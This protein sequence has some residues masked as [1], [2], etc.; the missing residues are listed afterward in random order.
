MNI[1]IPEIDKKYEVL[2]K[3]GEG[4]M[5]AVYRARHRLLDELRVIKTIRPMLREDTEVQ[6][7]FLN[8]AQV[9][10]KLRHRHI[11]SIH[12][13]AMGDDGT[14]CIVM[15]HIEGRNLRDHQ[16]AGPGLNVPQVV[17]VARQAL[18]ALA[19]MHE[20]R[21]VHRDIS[22]DNLML[23]WDDEGLP[24]VTLID[25]GLAKSLESPTAHTRTGTVVGKARYISPE[26]LSA[27]SDGVTVD[28]RCDLYA[29]G[30]V[31]YELLTGEYPIAGDDELALI[32]GHLHRPPRSFDQTDPEHRV[33]SALRGVV[34]QALEKA[35]ADRFENADAMSK[36][37]EVGSAEMF[38]RD[39]MPTARMS[40][41][42]GAVAVPSEDRTVLMDATPRRFRL[43]RRVGKALAVAAG[44]VALVV[45]GWGLIAGGVAGDRFRALFA[46]AEVD[47]LADVFF[48]SYHALIIG[49]DA[50]QRLPH[51]STAVNDARAIGDLLQRRYGFSVRLLENATRQEIM[52]ALWDTRQSLGARDNLLVYYA[53]HGQLL[54]RSEWWQPVDAEPDNTS[55]W[56]STRYDVS[57]QVADMA[58][59][60]ALVVADSCY[61]GAIG[62]VASPPDAGSDAVAFVRERVQRSSRMVMT[63]GG[64]APVLDAGD[65]RHSVFAKAFLEVLEG[66]Q[67]V[68]AASRIFAD[69]RPRVV[70]GA[71][72]FGFEQEPVLVV[73]PRTGDEGGEL[74][75][76]PAAA[77]T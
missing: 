64:L 70:T 17:H 47:P 15:E 28:A 24:F 11:A 18:D 69:L 32:A 42:S 44:L 3:L 51:L 66:N 59:R 62:E 43:P 53:G 31:L 56:I 58:V 9:A 23:D 21:L 46:S 55:N 65:A 34:M 68:A 20:R 60:H 41:A 7:R 38:A 75:F 35:P 67:E 16:R 76:V 74:F 52:D 33:P 71:R 54:N 10:A 14:A 13:F 19:Y 27:G 63:S 39:G 49:N 57:A 48:G 2:S 4:G 5:G 61:A 26:Q 6:N 8:E 22:T 40:T 29:M 45:A 72:Q 12:D 73:I 77:D 1:G 50:Y 30:V 37:L 36:A 25:L